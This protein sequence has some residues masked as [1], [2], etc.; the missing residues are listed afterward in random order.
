[1]AGVMPK[2]AALERSRSTV[3]E[4]PFG[5]RSLATSTIVGNLAQALQHLRRP[6]LQ[7]RQIL[8]LERELILRRAD[9]GVDRQVLH[10]LHEQR[11]AG[12]IGGLLL[13]PPD[14]LARGRRAL[15]R[16]A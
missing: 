13:Q 6:G 15:R 11:Y 4:R 8:V 14:D 12:D 7:R 1:M 9:G 2:R 10:R 5:C 16:A 3:T